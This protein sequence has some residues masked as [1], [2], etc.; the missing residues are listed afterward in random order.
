MTNFIFAHERFVTVLTHSIPRR[1]RR[2]VESR[3][4]MRG[5]G[6]R[7]IGALVAAI[8]AA[9]CG[10]PE[11]AFAP[12]DAEDGSS[13]AAGLGE[14]IGGSSGTAGG[15]G[16]GGE[17]G[18]GGSSGTPDGCDN[19]VQDGLETDVDCGGGCSACEPGS[20]CVLD[21]DC[22]TRCTS[23]KLCELYECSDD[24]ANGSET[25]ED[26]GGPDCDLR[27]AAGA[28]CRVDSDCESLLCREG[29]CIAGVCDPK[30]SPCGTSDCLCA[31]GRDCLRHDDCASGNCASG[32]CAVGARVFS[33]NDEP[34]ARDFPTPAILQ[35]FL[36]RNDAPAGLPLDE[37]SL[38]YF[39]SSDDVGD[40]PARCDESRAAPDVCSDIAT[41]VFTVAASSFADSYFEVRFSAGDVLAPG[42]QTSEIPVAVEPSGGGLYDQR[43]DY[44]FADNV[45][46][47]ANS[48]VTLYR[49]G[50]LVWGDEPSGFTTTTTTTH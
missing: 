35:A 30:S 41:P 36:V 17:S 42:A 13:G 6:I 19:G 4:P 3:Y 33:R 22:D 31:N 44:S 38:R 45:A 15:S 25:D 29:G 7:G 23:R 27:C 11:F 47:A 43:G 40:Q 9:S 46:F 39:F 50:V 5:A 14:P 12:D 48:K 10:W 1:A 24:V 18:R 21:V 37:L 8:V 2:M 34:S 16:A 26:C 20:P 28:E 49:R 32:T